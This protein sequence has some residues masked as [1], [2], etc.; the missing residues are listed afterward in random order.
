LIAAD[1]VSRTG[2]TENFQVYYNPK[3]QWYYLSGQKP[4]ELALF[5]QGDTNY[6]DRKC[7]SFNSINL[8]SFHAKKRI[9]VP[10]C[11]FRNP[12]SDPNE[13]PRESI[14]ARAFVFY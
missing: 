13:L 12:L 7:T 5:C 10:H 11:G 1:V 3:H 4:T 9:G 14:E 8:D 2:Y 6:I